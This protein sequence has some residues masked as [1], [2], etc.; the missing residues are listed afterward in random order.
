MTWKHG[1][2]F[3]W[4]VLRRWKWCLEREKLTCIAF[5]GNVE[6]PVFVLREPL[7]PIDEKFV[8][9][10][11]CEYHKYKNLEER[12]LEKERK[13]ERE[14]ERERD[15]FSCHQHLGDQMRYL[16]KRNQPQLV[17]PGKANSPLQ[18]ND[19]WQTPRWESWIQSLIQQRWNKME[20]REWLQ[21]FTCIPCIRV[22][23]ESLS[24]RAHPKGTHLL[25]GPIGHRRAPWP[26]IQPQDKRPGCWPT[27]LRGLNQ[28]VE[29]SPPRPWVH[30]DVARVLREAHIGR[31]PR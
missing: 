21:L 12:Y 28:P 15:L 6:R 4:V 11:C 1:I 9:V 10:F 16:S 22:Q 17:N 19:T 24:I 31:L 30:R 8:G 14:R 3:N 20:L 5:S 29:Q 13:R 23:M 7:K 2:N 27:A 25:W 18:S 26:T